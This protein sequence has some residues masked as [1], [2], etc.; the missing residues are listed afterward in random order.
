MSNT[1]TAD[2]PPSTPPSTSWKRS[3]FTTSQ[4][5][6][7]LQD[8]FDGFVPGENKTPVQ[9]PKP[10][11]LDYYSLFLYLLISPFAWLVWIVFAL[12][13]YPLGLLGK[14]YMDFC[15]APGTLFDDSWTL[16]VL[17]SLVSPYALLLYLFAAAWWWV[18]VVY[19][20]LMCSPVLLVRVFLF[21]Q[22][23]QV[24]HSFRLLRPFLTFNRFSYPGTARMCF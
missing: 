8:L 10:G 17:L 18:S 11:L 3:P 23:P 2:T 4:E 24:M 20:S 13:Y 21:G 9:V 19:I 7:V 14:L 16:T 15:V 12:G 22:G 6:A 1:S 5:D